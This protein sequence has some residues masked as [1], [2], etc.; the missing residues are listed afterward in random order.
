VE[1]LPRN[2]GVLEPKK[3]GFA[4]WKGCVIY[5]RKIAQAADFYEGRDRKSLEA[6]ISMNNTSTEMML[7]KTFMFSSSISSLQKPVLSL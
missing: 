3:Y 6:K 5:E 2:Q 7:K 1:T 4:V